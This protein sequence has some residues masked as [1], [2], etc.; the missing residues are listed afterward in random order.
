MRRGV[1]VLV[2]VAALLF[3][4]LL[5]A[6]RG[7]L[8][9]TFGSGGK[10]TTDFGGT[11]IA[12][13]I[14]LQRDG[15]IVVAGDRLDQRP[16]DDF[17][18]ARYTENGNLDP[19][20]DG[21]GRVAT[22]F[23]G[24][25][26]GAYDVEVQRDGK[27]VVAGSSRQG[28]GSNIALARYDRDGS[29]DPT[30]GTAGKVLTTSGAGTVDDAYAVSVQAD[31]KIVAGGGTRH[32]PTRAFAL[33]RYLPDGALDPTFGSGGRVTTPI[34]G[35]DNDR[36]FALTVQPDGKLVAAGG[37][38]EGASDV[39]VARYSQ[40][41]NLD[42]T[43]DGDGIAVASF[44]PRDT[45]PLDVLVQRDGKLLAPGYG[46]VTRFTADGSLD[47]SFTEAAEGVS[48]VVQ[49][50]TAAIQPNGRI[51]VVGTFS[52]GLS[53]DF[54]VARLTTSGRLDLTYGRSG[55]VSTDFHS[56]SEDHARDVV[57]SLD[58]KLT[59]AGTTGPS[60]NFAVARYNAIRFCVVPNVR[61]KTLSAARSSLTKALC[62]VGTVKRVHSARIGKGRVISQR[63]APRTRLTE[64]AKVNL[65]VSRGR[66][67]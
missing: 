27:I 18:L 38:Y 7:D 61:G 66:R 26:D 33:A 5:P 21:D 48:R 10:V 63:P 53:D 23:D 51:L 1:I 3:P 40:S 46:G 60:W 2:G 29:L 19:S 28:G 58:G 65:V 37:S 9:P 6:A 30:F 20:F 57:L 11:E 47:R 39:V 55:V 4:A 41:G 50:A 22:D 31:G 25:Q 16:S 35:R 44:R 24:R 17:V 64:L 34:P 14:A 36:V 43:F 12:W 45:V 67:R 13:A 56:N 52:G 49:P 54:G 32:G 62:K 42:P 15:R 59:V 8:D